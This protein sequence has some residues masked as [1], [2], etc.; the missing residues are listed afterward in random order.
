METIKRSEIPV[1]KDR[2]VLFVLLDAFRWDYL[3]P[4][5]APTIHA[6][7]K[8]SIYV[9]KL[10][11]SSGF[12]QRSAIFTGAL[13][14]V[15][16]NYTMYVQDP[17]NSPFKVLRPF[18]WILRK[19]NPEHGLIYKIV[20]KFINQVPKFTTEWAPPGKIPSDVLPMIGVIEDND[21][22]DQPGT[23]PLHSLFDVFREHGIDY[24]YFMAPI[25]KHDEPT[26]QNVL[27]E[28]R[29]GG[30]VFFAQFSDT[31][32]LVHRDGVASE[33]RHRVVREVDERVR[34]LKVAMD[35]RFEDPWIVICGDHG[36]TDCH[37]YLDIWNPVQEEARKMGFV[38]GVDYL[39]F[40]DSTLA[41]FWFY[42]DEA[43]K[44]LLPFIETLLSEK[45]E[46]MTD[47]YRKE[48]GIA[49]NPEWYGEVIWKAETGI[50]IFPDY[51]HGLDDKYIGM[52]GFD[53]MHDDMK[54]VGVM[55]NA[56]MNATLEIEEGGLESMCAT[57]CDLLEL[58]TPNAATGPSFVP[59]N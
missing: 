41:R 54:G 37:E 12:T 6:L 28:I 57:L 16:G 13:S 50:G 20:R 51:F 19:I 21:P 59:K 15:H 39:M 29:D 44:K 32:A 18:R 33:T 2:G 1:G 46:W 17:K 53:C 9:K 14:D 26:M 22:I 4:E 11:S 10:V 25:S 42:S 43:R 3:T 38:R 58:P 23:L 7:T 24:R 34:K 49:D 30:Q 48:R 47:A 56:A 52:H 8:N 55:S 27:N 45:G 36:M 35:E 5:D 31:D 40:L